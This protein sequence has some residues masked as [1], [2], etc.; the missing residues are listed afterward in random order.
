VSKEVVSNTLAA[1]LSVRGVSIPP[2]VAA[3]CWLTGDGPVPAGDVIVFTNGV[4]DVAAG[5]FRKAAPD[6]FNH[7][8]FNF[9]YDPKATCPMWEKVVLE[10]LGS[11]ALVDLW[12]EFCGYCLTPDTKYEKAVLFYGTGGNGKST[13]RAPLEAVMGNANRSSL[14]LDQFGDRFSLPL[15]QGKLVNICADQ[16]G[17]TI[18]G[19]A[20]GN[21]RR[22]ISGE[23]IAI[24]R[25]G[26]DVYDYIPTA[27]LVLCANNWPKFV[28]KSDAF[29]MRFIVIELTRTFR[30]ADGDDKGLKTAEYWANERAGFVNWALVGLRRLRRRGRFEIPAEAEP[31]ARK[32]WASKSASYFLKRFVRSA[33]GARSPIDDLYQKYEAQTRDAGYPSCDKTTFGKAV[34]ALFPQIENGRMLVAEGRDTA[35]I[36]IEYVPGGV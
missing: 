13:L 20:E 19:K 23:P 9:D 21:L 1:L 31:A 33:D 16:G 28:D 32:C 36:G 14:G 25:K 4:L 24:E 8:A 5:S 17:V 34:R 35:Y 27:K 2:E 22:F 10:I 18:A 7:Q 15:T 11:P 6:L 30:D 3:P 26:I 29:P 12:Q